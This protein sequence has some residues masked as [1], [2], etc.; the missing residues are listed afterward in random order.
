MYLFRLICRDGNMCKQHGTK[1]ARQTFPD[2]EQHR[3][4]VDNF[5]TFILSV[6]F[7]LFILGSFECRQFGNISQHD[8]KAV[9]IRL[10]TLC[11]ALLRLCLERIFS[12][13]NPVCLDKQFDLLNTCQTNS[14]TGRFLCLKRKQSKEIAS[15]LV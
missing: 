7:A 3:E 2:S 9:F 12:K 5:H 11:T 15:I 1:C 8:A 13:C 6:L 14:Q 10:C 4:P